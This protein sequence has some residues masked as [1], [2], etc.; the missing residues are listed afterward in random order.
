MEMNTS[1]WVTQCGQSNGRRSYNERRNNF[2]VDCNLYSTCPIVYPMGYWSH[3]KN[4]ERE[5]VIMN[6]II[7]T[8]L[9]GILVPFG[10]AAV[11]YGLVYLC[12]KLDGGEQRSHQ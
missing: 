9:F 12:Y 6:P 3:Q 4:V 5:E 10:M 7:Q 11:V 8:F 2:I 1:R